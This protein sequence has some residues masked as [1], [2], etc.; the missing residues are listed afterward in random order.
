MDG[1]NDES[2]SDEAEGLPMNANDTSYR[3]QQSGGLTTYDQHGS[4]TNGGGQLQ[5]A[6]QVLNPEGGQDPAKNQRQDGVSATAV[7]LNLGQ[8]SGSIGD[9]MSSSAAVEN[10]SSQV[11]TE[12]TSTSA[13]TVVIPQEYLTVAAAAT[14]T[15]HFVT[16]E[17]AHNGI[18]KLF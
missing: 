4:L 3:V 11:T 10:N 9:G 6:T 18:K 17:Q 8:V 7:A 13:G 12:T 14:A 16:T 15:P 1:G 5:A 2:R